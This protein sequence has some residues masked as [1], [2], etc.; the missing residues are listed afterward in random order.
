MCVSMLIVNARLQLQC[1]LNG[2][3]WTVSCLGQNLFSKASGSHHRKIHKK[4]QPETALIV[5]PRRWLANVTESKRDRRQ[6]PLDG[7]PANASDLA[8][9]YLPERKWEDVRPTD[10]TLGLAKAGGKSLYLS[11]QPEPSAATVAT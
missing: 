6:S 7:L 5:V 3:F 2:H 10:W 11:F 9:A 1:D 4:C 8:G